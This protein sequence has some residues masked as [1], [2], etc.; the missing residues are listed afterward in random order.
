LPVCLNILIQLP[1]IKTVIKKENKLLKKIINDNA[2]DLV[3]SDNRFG[4]YDQR[5]ENIFIT[6]QLNIKSPFFSSMATEINLKYIHKFTKVWVPDH[7]NENDRLSGQLSDSKEV[8]IPVEY[9]GPKSALSIFDLDPTSSEKCDH[10]ILLSGVEPQRSILERSLLE[11]FKGS[12]K[13][14][15]LVRGSN[16]EI[17]GENK[18][19]TAIDFAFGEKLKGL[20]LNADTIICRSGYSTLMDLHLLKKEKII[21]IPTPGQTEQE[22]LAQY[23][24]EKFSSKTIRQKNISSCNF[25]FGL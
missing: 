8:K 23:W 6:H 21:L 10:L 12:T 11:K 24:K 3:I 2:I 13:K 22:Y 17:K 4:L 7:K 14:I 9:I 1:K 16:T 15:I 5:V 18:N 19:I 20:I 25:D